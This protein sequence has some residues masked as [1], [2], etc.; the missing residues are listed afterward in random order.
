M[1]KRSIMLIVYYLALFLLNDGALIAK[2]LKWYKIRRILF[3]LNSITQNTYS[4][5]VQ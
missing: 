2:L 3:I 1:H 4:L 5:V